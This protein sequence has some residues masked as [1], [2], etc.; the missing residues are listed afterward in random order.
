[1]AKEAIRISRSRQML[2]IIT[3]FMIVQFS[4][5]FLASLV[6]SGLTINQV[7]SAHIASS[8]NSVIFYIFYIVIMALILV[9][10]MRIYRGDKLFVVFEGIVIF[11]A[12]FFVFLIGIGAATH[13]MQSALF[14]SGVNEQVILAA[15]LALLLV[16]AKNKWQGLRNTAAIIASVGVGIV[17]GISFSFFEALLFMALLAV[18]DFIAVFI[19][20][21]MIT[22]ANAAVDR[23]LALF[24][25][26]SEIEAVPEAE[27]PSSQIK[28]FEEM[29]KRAKKKIPVLKVLRNKK[30]V[31]IEVPA[32][33]GTGDLAVPLM[34]SVSAYSATLSFTLSL[35]VALG[36]VFGL[37]ITMFI[38]QK[39]NRALPA[40]P[41]L[42]LGVLIF[43]GL[44]LLIY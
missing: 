13:N 11:I 21:H 24:I 8:F 14:S 5:L 34:V 33:L 10:V 18:Y 23:N 35:F 20:K 31:P 40:I 38:L 41:P 16:I 26:A 28:R 4:G 2:S 42:L 17:L 36:A 19:T 12:S 43:V 29:K 32:M 15:V 37:I 22:I 9:F 27:F 7:S 25:G 44:Y 1:M 6:F 39:L 30:L 3:M